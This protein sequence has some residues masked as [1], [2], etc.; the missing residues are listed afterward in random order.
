ML[1]PYHGVIYSKRI[2]HPL[3]GVQDF[4][5]RDITV[6]I[7]VDDYSWF[8]FIAFFDGGIAEENAQNVHFGIIGYLHDTLFISVWPPHALAGDF[9]GAISALNAA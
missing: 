2:I 7:M 1:S 3:G 9:L 8:V 5:A 6:F 4:H